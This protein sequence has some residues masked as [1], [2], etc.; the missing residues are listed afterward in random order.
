MSPR[1]KNK[2]K[3]KQNSRSVAQTPTSLPVLQPNAGGIDIGAR[4]IFVAVPPGRDPRPVRAFATFTADLHALR[5]WL[6]AC[7]VTTVVMESTGVYWIPLFQILESAGIE[8]CLVNARHCKN[9][10]GRKTD[11]QDC[12]WLQ[13]LHSVGLLRGSFRPADQVCA[14]RSLLRHRDG[15]VRAAATCVHRLHKALTQMNVQLQHVIADVTGV[16]GLAILEAILAGERDPVA[17]AKLRDGRIRASTDTITKSLR[18]DWRSEH[19]FTLRQGLETWK[20]YQAQLTACDAETA[21]L[22]AAFDAKVDGAAHPLPPRT[23]TH[24]SPQKNEPRFAAREELYRTCGVDLTQVPGFQSGTALVLVGELGP[25]FAE[26]FPTAK[27]FGSWLGLCPDN[28]ITGGKIMSSSTRDVNSRAATAL[29]LAAQGL[30]KAQNYFGDLYRRWKA[31]LGTPKAIT[32]MAHKLA[33][34]LWHLFKYREAFNPE[35]FR[36]EAEKM[37][38]KKL[39]RLHNTAAALGLKLVPAQ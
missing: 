29:R 27:H 6:Q 12:Q 13:Y 1:H 21:R 4:E 23:S 35:V 34:I 22:L 39:A 11:V 9:L 16:T 30:N 31:R 26:R 24:K 18:G 19:L 38:R 25:D 32:A 2:I 3:S 20:H 10:P 14:V 5:D 8:V 7:G 17:L 37:K 28:R 15:L 33:R 36:K